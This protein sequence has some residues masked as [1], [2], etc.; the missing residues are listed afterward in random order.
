MSRRTDHPSLYN[1][2][3]HACC[4]TLS[5]TYRLFCFLLAILNTSTTAFSLATL[6]M[7]SNLSIATTIYTSRHTAVIS[8]LCLCGWV[9]IQLALNTLIGGCERVISKHIYLHGVPL[10]K[11]LSLRVPASSSFLS[12][13]M[14][15]AT[16]REDSARWE[17]VTHIVITLSPQRG[18]WH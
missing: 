9:T 6:N 4:M 15:T 16:I 13:V 2:C 5:I 8:H 11:D 17:R 10:W 18:Q 3:T 12:G 1:I 7:S 14:V